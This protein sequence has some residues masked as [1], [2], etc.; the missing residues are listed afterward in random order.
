[1]KRMLTTVTI[2]SALTLSAGAA[3]AADGKAVFT[4]LKCNSCH[5]VDSQGIKAVEEEPEE[6][7]EP[8]KPTDLSDAGGKHDAKWIKDWLMKKVDVDGK[9]HRKK[10]AGTPAQLDAVAT[11][12]ASLKAAK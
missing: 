5:S 7:E 9:K 10:F 11:W 3:G 6:G 8:V 12:L 2:A 4:E 1:M